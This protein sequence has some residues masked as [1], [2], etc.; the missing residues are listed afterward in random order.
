M[1]VNPKL[2]MLL[3]VET[4]E[5]LIQ[6]WYLC[7]YVVICIEGRTNNMDVTVLITIVLAN[8]EICNMQQT[9][10]YTTNK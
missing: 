1:K 3:M 5:R 4:N 10:R 8:M 7:S 6:E 9:Y 2:I